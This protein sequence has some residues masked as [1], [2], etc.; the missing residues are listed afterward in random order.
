VSDTV[1]LIA[2]ALG[3]AISVL[4]GVLSLRRRDTVSGVGAP[5]VVIHPSVGGFVDAVHQCASEADDRYVSALG[6]LRTDPEGAAR[7]IED[8]Y[9][10]VGADRLAPRQ[11]L[12]LAAAALR[13]RA[14][15]P[16]LADVAR[17][18]VAGDLRHDGGR[19]AE[20]S[21]LRLIAVDGIEAIA[22]TGDPN[23]AD[24]L[25]SLVSSVDRAV[26]AAAVVALKY[27]DVQGDRVAR[28][29]TLL[30][31]DRADLLDIRRAHV[32]EVPQVSDPRRH[33]WDLPGTMDT[34]PDPETGERRNGLPPAKSPSPRV[35]G[36]R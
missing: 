10:A 20:E 31:P 11:A 34:R 19:A 4:V 23:A 17:R 14:I 35:P 9:R 27:S 26:Q 2:A 30:P 8:A 16:F 3:A 18:P 13:H 33:L 28:L 25:V 24:E 36:G 5:D 22:R 29:R 7:H 15:L 32:T 1:I 12:L 21:A 6:L